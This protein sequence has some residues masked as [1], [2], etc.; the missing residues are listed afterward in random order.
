MKVPICRQYMLQLVQVLGSFGTDLAEDLPP[1]RFRELPRTLARLM[2]ECMR[3]NRPADSPGFRAVSGHILTET[4]M[5]SRPTGVVPVNVS[6]QQRHQAVLDAASIL[7][8]GASPHSRVRRR[9]GNS[10]LGRLARALS[11]DLSA[12][13]AAPVSGSL[14]RDI[15]AGRAAARELEGRIPRLEDSK[16]DPL[17]LARRRMEAARSARRL[18]GMLDSATTKDAP[19]ADI[20]VRSAASAERLAEL[21]DRRVTAA[22]LTRL[23]LKRSDGQGSRAGLARPGTY[24]RT[25]PDGCHRVGRITPRLLPATLDV[26]APGHGQVR[27]SGL[28]RFFPA[29]TVHAQRSTAVV[30][31]NNCELQSTDH[32]HVHRISVSLDQLLR[33]G[34]PGHMALR[35]LM[36]D[37]SSGGITRFQDSLRRIANPPERRVTQASVPVQADHRTSVTGA[38]AVQ[39]GDWSRMIVAS[40]YVMEQA[41][42][43]I[44]D[45]LA[46]DKQ[47]VRSLLA[48][49]GETTAGPATSRFLRNALSAGGRADDLDLLEHGTI[50]RAPRTSILGLF[51]VD[52]ADRAA[53]VMVGS[54]NELTASMKVHR[55]SLARGS[56]VDD[57]GRVRAQAAKIRQAQ[58]SRPTPAAAGRLVSG[59]SPRYAAGAVEPRMARRVVT[60]RSLSAN[61]DVRR[62]SPRSGPSR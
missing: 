3:F 58:L 5:V 54:G 9:G 27:V 50:P 33:P 29:H 7:S 31:G 60:G 6:A 16:A 22:S 30:A 37:Q 13:E 47:L 20:L 59:A 34:T 46:R 55:G 4:A 8:P 39:L 28:A 45:L 40:R 18:A 52:V 1:R 44:I 21:L 43:P 42:L 14:A 36:L 10:N 57:L 38:K 35:A 23:P 26:A 62:V 15:R 24:E 19:H 53:A 32:Y 61:P 11:R 49:A 51:G 17:D 12:A 48:A 25:S 2:I 41:E 56:I